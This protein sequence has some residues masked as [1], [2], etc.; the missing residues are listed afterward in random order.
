[1]EE[2]TVVVEEVRRQWE[3]QMK[4]GGKDSVVVFAV[5]VMV[6]VFAW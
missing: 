6:F 2:P 3:R 1:L 4:E 5:K